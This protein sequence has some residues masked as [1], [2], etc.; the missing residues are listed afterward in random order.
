M[1]ESVREERGALREEGWKMMIDYRY[2]SLPF[3]VSEGGHVV[4]AFWVPTTRRGCLL[5]SIIPHCIYT[6]Q[7]R[8]S[9]SQYMTNHPPSTI[10][11][12]TSPTES[13]TS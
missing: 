4:M 6:H 9:P 8:F 5:F 3:M 13:P 11:L 1:M 7:Q 10:L 2:F 12:T